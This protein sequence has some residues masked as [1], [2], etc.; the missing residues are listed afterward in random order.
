VTAYYLDSSVAVRI[1]LGH[2]PHAAA[3]FDATT[4]SDDDRV[5]SSRLLRTE[6]TRVLRREGLPVADRDQILDYLDTI[7]LD[8]AVLQEAEAIVVHLRTL[9]AVHLGSALRSGLDDLTV[10]TH[11]QAMAA[12]ATQIG[13]RVHD[14]VESGSA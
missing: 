2:S 8:H 14:P 13:F 12:V 10:V 6:L 9:D 11:D 1:V 5:I 4:G 7:P 3:W